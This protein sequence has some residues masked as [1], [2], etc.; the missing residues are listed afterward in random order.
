MFALGGVSG[1]ASFITTDEQLHK[2]E[3]DVFSCSSFAILNYNCDVLFTIVSK[4]KSNDIWFNAK[5]I[6]ICVYID[7]I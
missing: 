3:A 4:Q 1:V 6:L 5:T 7:S 2:T